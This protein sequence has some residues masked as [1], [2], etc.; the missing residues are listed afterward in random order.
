MDIQ[1][2]ALDEHDARRQI[3]ASSKLKETPVIAVNSIAMRSDEER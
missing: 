2:P 1:L 3:K